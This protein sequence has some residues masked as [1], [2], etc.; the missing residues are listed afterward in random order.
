ME[1]IPFPFKF[2]TKV[3]AIREILPLSYE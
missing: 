1:K 3:Q 2:G